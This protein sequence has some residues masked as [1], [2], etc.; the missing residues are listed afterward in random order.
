[1]ADE[2]VDTHAIPPSDTG[3]EPQEPTQTESQESQE[4]QET[5]E[6][7]ETQPEPPQLSQDDIIKKAADYSL[8]QMRSWQGRRD[9]DL[10]DAIDNRL[11]QLQTPQP[12]TQPIAPSTSSVDDVLNNPDAWLEQK[13][14]NLVPRMLQSEIQ[15]MQQ[16]EQGYTTEFI[17]QAGN[18][19]DTDPLFEDKELGNAVVLE[20]KN[21][22]GNLDKRLPP[23]YAAQLS[24]S[25][26]IASVMRKQKAEKH[27][28]LAGNQPGKAV[29]GIKPPPVPTQKIKIPK[30]SAEAEKLRKRW[31]YTDE[32]LARL[33]PEG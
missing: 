7:Q 22:M 29:G 32:D 10:F 6:T 16:A 24:V 17:K 26:A 31:G 33:F 15:K 11:R 9:R 23:N 30:L 19:L 21:S 13:A 1:M 14:A 5:Q 12:A 25:N 18:I 3:N 4:S 20:I 27:N 28:P 2:P 8:Q